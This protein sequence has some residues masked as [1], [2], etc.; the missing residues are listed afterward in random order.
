MADFEVSITDPIERSKKE[1]AFES[2][3]SRSQL[4]CDMAALVGIYT[5]LEQYYLNE[6]FK[7][8]VSMDT[9][10]GDAQTSSLVDDAFYIIKKSVRRA[11]ASSSVDGVCAMLNHSVNLI[12]TQL[13]SGF[14]QTLRKGFPVQ[15]YLDLT[16]AY[17]A[18]Q[19][20]LQSGKLNPTTG[21]SDAL[22]QIFLVNLNNCNISMQHVNSLHQS[23][24]ENIT[25]VMSN[26]ET[27]QAKLDSCMGDLKSTTA[28]LSNVVEFGMSQLRATA[29]KPKIK[30][31]VDQFTTTSHDISE[32]EFAG[33]EANDPFSQ[34]LM[35]Q[36]DGLLGSF[37]PLLTS[38]N[39]KS[40]VTLVVAEVAA[41]LEKAVLKS[42]FNRLGGLQFDREVRAIVAY[43]SQASEWSVREQLA[44]LTQIATLLNLESL[45]EVSEY[46]N[47]TTWRLTP[48][49][50][51]QVLQLRYESICILNTIG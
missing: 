12:E 49:E 42:S 51:R 17:T 35:V 38:E 46:S 22:R 34:T 29:I 4:A 23:L 20:S 30:P 21:D 14:H 19:T 16:Q 8:A 2:K 47:T 10:E 18:L 3:L 28:K 7:K 25:S 32:S 15:G 45:S 44:R 13:A 1:N 26:S 24:R 6:S 5:I 33:Y 31:W 11:I 36:V 39:Y 48:S 41:Q 43:L 40:L 27:T 37:L 50:M 9:V